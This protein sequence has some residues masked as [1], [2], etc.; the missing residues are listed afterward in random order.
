MSSAS[1]QTIL[2]RVFKI[3][4]YNL[5]YHPKFSNFWRNFNFNAVDLN[6]LFQNATYG[7]DEFFGQ[8]GLDGSPDSKFN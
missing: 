8:Y 3:K 7:K 6:H 5:S 2:I 4:A 1:K